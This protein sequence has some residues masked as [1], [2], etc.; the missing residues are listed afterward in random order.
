MEVKP[1]QKLSMLTTLRSLEPGQSVTF[2]PPINL[3][4]L[5]TQVSVMR[6]EL[7]NRNALTMTTDPESNAVVVTRKNI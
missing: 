2:Y 5:R 6:K 7:G 4:S 3:A 1:V